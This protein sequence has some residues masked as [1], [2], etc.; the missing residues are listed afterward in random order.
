MVHSRMKIEKQDYKEG[1]LDI[2]FFEKMPPTP[3]THLTLL[4]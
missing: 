3:G 4:K 2:T 1:V